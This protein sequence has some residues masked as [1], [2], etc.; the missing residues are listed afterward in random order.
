MFEKIEK[1]VF[2]ETDDIAE[3][4]ATLFSDDPGFFRGAN[5]DGCDVTGLDKPE[6]LFDGVSWRGVVV[7]DKKRASRAFRN[8][9]MREGLT[10]SEKV[11][12]AAGEADEI[13]QAR[14]DL[15]LRIA[16]FGPDHLNVGFAQVNLGLALE[17]AAQWDDAIVVLREG[18]RIAEALGTDHGLLGV[19]LSGLA[20]ALREQPN[21]AG[22]AGDERT[23]LFR[24]IAG[25]YRRAYKHNR[26][27]HVELHMGT[28]T[29]LSNLAGTY[30]ALGDRRRARRIAALAL[31][32]SRKVLAPGDPRLANTLNNLGAMH[33]K[34]R[35]PDRA[36][37]M[38]E[39][40]LEIRETAF[41]DI[42]RHP[43]RINTAGWLA[44]CRLALPEPDE[45]GARALCTQYGFDYD[46]RARRAAQCRPLT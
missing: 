24:Q 23:V 14:S 41:A 39:E 20:L 30:D 7:S 22:M 6:L 4:H 40:A 8:A 26:R 37:P 42:P 3:I 21:V 31:A 10:K 34:D 44:T 35:A 32:T 15:A 11:N 46:E 43:L 5:F 27:L 9:E 18:L 28:A 33:L 17:S 1:I 12:A 29:D 45:A 25:L 2:C 19:C 36:L 38:L 16:Q 13:R